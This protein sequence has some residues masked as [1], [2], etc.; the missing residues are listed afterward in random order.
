MLDKSTRWVEKYF[1]FFKVSTKFEIYSVFW[2]TGNICSEYRLK[3]E[4]LLVDCLSCDR[5]DFSPFHSRFA[6]SLSWVQGNSFMADW[7]TSLQ[8]VRLLGTHRWHQVV[9]SGRPFYWSTVFDEI[10]RVVSN[11]VASSPFLIWACHWKFH[12]INMKN[13]V[14]LVSIL[15]A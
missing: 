9:R 4:N 10:I 8:T 2:W 7:Q 3:E 6:S 11:L 14:F 1:A 15:T 12:L 5:P 13:Q